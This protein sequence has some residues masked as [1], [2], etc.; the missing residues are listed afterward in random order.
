[1]LAASAWVVGWDLAGDVVLVLHALAGVVL[2]Y[3]LGRLF[4]LARPWA[5]AGAPPRLP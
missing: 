4:G 2:V 3:R 5:A 1:M